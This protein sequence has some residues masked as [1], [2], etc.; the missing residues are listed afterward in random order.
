[1]ANESVE[2]KN[3][4]EKEYRESGNIKLTLNNISSVDDTKSF[5]GKMYITDK[6]IF[7]IPE[8]AED[9]LSPGEAAALSLGALGTFLHGIFVNKG[10]P[11]TLKEKVYQLPLTLQAQY[12]KGSL[13]VN[14]DSI[15]DINVAA[16]VAIRT[17][18]DNK[19]ICGLGY[20]KEDKEKIKNALSE[21]GV[22]VT[23]KG[24]FQSLLGR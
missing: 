9:I 3:V 18:K 22:T 16:S 11:A 10:K 1:M 8:S 17:K 12:I 13:Q 23:E 15:S 2:V 19:W 5:T 6:S 14:L 21:L 20:Q 4:I 24:F 7:F